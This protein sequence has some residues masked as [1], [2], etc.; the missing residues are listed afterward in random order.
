MAGDSLRA[1]IVMLYSIKLMKDEISFWAAGVQ[2][3]MAIWKTNS[4]HCQH[5][6]CQFGNNLTSTESM[7]TIREF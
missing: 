4:F 3:F 6:F 1:S 7:L 2:K 5:A